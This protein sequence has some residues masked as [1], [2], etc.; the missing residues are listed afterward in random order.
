LELLIL[1]QSNRVEST[2]LAAQGA[3]LRWGEKFKPSA[4]NTGQ[5]EAIGT[6]RQLCAS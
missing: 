2:M 4:V 1:F 6:G 3:L 5:L